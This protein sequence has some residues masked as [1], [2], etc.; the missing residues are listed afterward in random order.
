LN[1]ICKTADTLLDLFNV[2]P[3]IQYERPNSLFFCIAHFEFGNLSVIRRLAT[4][5]ISGS[6]TSNLR[7]VAIVAV[8]NISARLIV[9]K[10][11]SFN[12]D[13]FFSQKKLAIARSLAQLLK[14][15]FMAAFE[16]LTT[17]TISVIKHKYDLC[18][19]ENSFIIP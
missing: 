14:L 1:S 4:Q 10:D 6:E 18:E 16:R 17:I 19:N 11:F 13:L 15:I 2:Y 7:E 12:I 3:E 5:H 8:S 9:R